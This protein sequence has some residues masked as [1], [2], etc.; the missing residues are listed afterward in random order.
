MVRK[1]HRCRLLHSC[2]SLAFGC[3]L[4][5]CAASAQ[6][7]D[8]FKNPYKAAAEKFRNRGFQNPYNMKEHGNGTL[9][10]ALERAPKECHE[11]LRYQHERI[12]AGF[13]VT[14]SCFTQTTK[15]RLDYIPDE[16]AA[17]K[18]SPE[19]LAVFASSS[20]LV[21]VIPLFSGPEC[22]KWLALSLLGN[23]LAT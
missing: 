18:C 17:L 15:L 6:K 2:P 13:L 1:N 19:A 3:L 22:A 7:P 5:M 11:K 23:K 9:E 20:P 8:D 12:G 14:H 4:M 21:A 10:S 16:V